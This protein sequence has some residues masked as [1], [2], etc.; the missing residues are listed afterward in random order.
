MVNMA[1]NLV[2][3]AGTPLLGL[4]FALPGDGRIGFLAT[5]GLWIAALLVVPGVRELDS[6]RLANSPG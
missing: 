4:T 2:V 5:I 6:R 3:V 1:A